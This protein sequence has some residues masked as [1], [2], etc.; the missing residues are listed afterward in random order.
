MSHILIATLSTEPQ[1]VTRVLDALLQRGYPM[2]EVAV[3]HTTGDAIRPA[4]ERLDAEFEAGAY[5]QIRYRRIPLSRPDGPVTDIRSEADVGAL[6]QALYRTLRAARLAN[7]TIHLSITSGRKTMA[8]YA[9]VAAQLLFR[10]ED[11]V[12]HMLSLER[13]SGGEK[14]MHAEPGEPVELISV[15]V[16]RWSDASAAAILDSTDDPWEAIRR[17]RQLAQADLARRQREFLERY[18]TPAERRVCELLVREGLD[19]TALANRLHLSEQTVANHLSKI[20]RKFGEWR[21]TPGGSRAALI[22]EFAGYLAAQRS[23]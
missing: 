3:I 14:R 19:N 2:G 22:A 17:Q 15:P 9:M 12:W 11:R 1:G 18:L 21:G 23:P 13:W 8:V 20:Y 7:Q 5:P 6:L 16:L 4:I 10:E